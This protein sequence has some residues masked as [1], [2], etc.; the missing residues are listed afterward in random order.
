MRRTCRLT[1]HAALWKGDRTG[2]DFE[3]LVARCEWGPLTLAELPIVDRDLSVDGVP[4]MDLPR[5]VFE[6]T[7][8]IVQ[9]RH[10]VLNWLLGFERLYSEVTTDT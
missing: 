4:L 1:V 5:G 10:Q 2:M 8:S 6:T 7:R 9:E 3:E